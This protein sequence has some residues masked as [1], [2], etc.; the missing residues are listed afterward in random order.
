MVSWSVGGR[1]ADVSVIDKDVIEGRCGLTLDRDGE[2]EI[3]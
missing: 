3:S 2:I 1:H